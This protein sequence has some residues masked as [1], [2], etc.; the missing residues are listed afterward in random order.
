VTLYRSF[1][2]MLLPKDGIIVLIFCVFILILIS[3][4]VRIFFPLILSI[5]NPYRSSFSPTLRKFVV[6]KGDSISF[7]QFGSLP[8]HRL[9]ASSIIEALTSLTFLRTTQFY[10][11]SHPKY[12]ALKRCHFRDSALRDDIARPQVFVAPSVA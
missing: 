8:P 5:S 12:L 2:C 6:A 7:A 10:K 1:C 4:F 3:A 11:D 9:L